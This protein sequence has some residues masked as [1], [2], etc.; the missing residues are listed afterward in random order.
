[1]KIYSVKCRV[2]QR[3][4]YK[5]VAATS[6]DKVKELLSQKEKFLEIEDIVEMEI[7]SAQVLHC[8]L[9]E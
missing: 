1:M 4:Y 9:V 5:I 6:E 3:P 2:Y 7:E 8:H